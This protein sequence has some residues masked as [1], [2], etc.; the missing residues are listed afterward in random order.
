M[1]AAVERARPPVCGQTKTATTNVKTLHASGAGRRLKWKGFKDKQTPFERDDR[2]CDNNSQRLQPYVQPGN[3]L[4]E[5]RAA[6]IIC[7]L[8]AG[9]NLF[10]SVATDA[11][12][13]VGRLY[14]SN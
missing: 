13:A 6:R 8:H 12:C 1:A 5:Y 10:W 7:T 4:Q 3:Q 9:V 11:E 2:N 14:R